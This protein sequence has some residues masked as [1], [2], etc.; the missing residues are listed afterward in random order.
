MASSD[1][2]ETKRKA[3]DTLRSVSAESLSCLNSIGL[4]ERTQTIIDAMTCLWM[5]GDAQI[6]DIIHHFVPVL[7]TTPKMR[8]SKVLAA[9]FSTTHGAGM[10]HEMQL[11]LSRAMIDWA[12]KEKRNFVRQRLQ[13][14][15]AQLLHRAGKFEES[16]D[17][18]EPLIREGLRQD[19]KLLL[20]EL[21]LLSSECYYAMHY[22]DKAGG[23]LMAARANSNSTYCEQSL[24]ARLDYHSGLV[25]LKAR[26]RGTAHSFFC[27][28][29]E[30]FHKIDPA[31]SKEALKL[32]LICKVE[33]KTQNQIAQ[34]LARK[35]IDVR[36]SRIIAAVQSLA[37]AYAQ[38][39]TE[40]FDSVIAENAE[41]LTSDSLTA[42]I[43]REM[44]DRLINMRLARIIA[45]YSRIEIAYI[46]EVMK[47]TPGVV[48][49][50]LSQMILDKE[51]HA[52][53]DQRARCLVMKYEEDEQAE[54]KEA[55]A[56][57][58]NLGE[59]VTLL[60]QS[61]PV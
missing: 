23:A 16:L 13:H 17:I 49:S 18:L 33:A 34:V 41:S 52:L 40:R 37:E 39:D 12:R 22:F 3:Y 46:A 42:D 38:C 59:L 19:D 5:S 48:E 56:A 45:P 55:L 44:Y 32:M 2:A 58:E 21:Y 1:I 54:K 6:H 25:A 57:I 30:N 35:N 4:L 11:C 51:L 14:R 27:E 50:R 26:D 10:S 7:E 24:Q 15:Y 43:L 53:I 20:T 31:K 9:L 36:D 28:S 29:F 60:T 61:A 47:L 8:L